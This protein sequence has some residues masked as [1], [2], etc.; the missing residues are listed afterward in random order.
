MSTRAAIS[1]VFA[2][3][4]I[5][6]TG[7]G[8]GAVAAADGMTLLSGASMADGAPARQVSPRPG[9]GPTSMQV[10]PRTDAASTASAVRRPSGDAATNA[11]IDAPTEPDVAATARMASSS[12]PASAAATA[13]P[14]D[15]GAGGAEDGLRLASRD[16][17]DTNALP[18]GIGGGGAAAHE[19]AIASRSFTRRPYVAIGAGASRLDPESP[20]QALTI[21]EDT[22]FAGEIGVGYDFTRW[23]SAE[24]HA[25]DLGGAGIDFLGSDV[26][27]LGY[28]VYGGSALFYLFNLRDGFV[29]LASGL[30]GAHRREGLSLF[31]RFG[32]GGLR[33][34]SERVAYRR[35]YASHAVFGAGLEYG[36]RNGFALRAEAQAF[37]TDARYVG[38]SVLK[39]FGGVAMAAPLA[40]AAPAVVPPAAALPV[41]EPA[42][43]PVVVDLPIV[44]FAFD[45]STLRPESL[46]R[47]DGFVEAVENDDRRIMVDGHTDWIGAE[48]Y[49]VGLSDR[50]AAAVRD[51]FVSRGID[52]SRIT[53]RGFG[54]TRPVTRNTTEEGRSLNRRAEVRFE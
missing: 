41:P 11:P 44:H 35:D 25:A 51:Y 53:A 42:P 16:E 30:K 15:S 28:Q 22:S 8:L 18:F 54:E 5:V 6:L 32:I 33:N 47:L 38:V 27:E 14:I 2:A 46:A 23:L 50:R 26:G 36:F 7:T 34:D 20:S 43:T 12:A 40:A 31:T 9:A 39:R 3:L 17:S 24:F 29:P 49:N 13:L 4:A 19:K 1:R 21:E 48:R 37:D 45:R 10:S 52:A